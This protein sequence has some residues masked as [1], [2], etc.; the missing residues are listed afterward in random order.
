MQQDT[1]ARTHG[2]QQHNQ[3][4][5]AY[6]KQP[7]ISY[8][9]STSSGQNMAGISNLSEWTKTI[10]PTSFGPLLFTYCDWGG[11]SRGNRRHMGRNGI[12]TAFLPL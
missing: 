7:E 8:V 1:V 10:D 11:A 3:N 12:T 4:Y 9:D 5:K 6:I 2:A